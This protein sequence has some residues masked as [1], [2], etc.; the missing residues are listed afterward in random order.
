M[1]TKDPENVYE[2]RAM[3]RDAKQS[4]PAVV[5]DPILHSKV[6]QTPKHIQ[7]MKDGK[8]PLE[9][10]ITSVEE[11]DAR[12]LRGGAIKYG[13]RNWLIDKILASTYDGAI[14]RH[15][16]LWL[17]GNDVDPDSG[18]HPFYHI[19]ACCAIVLDAEKNGMLVDDRDR[20]ESISQ[21]QEAEQEQPDE[22]T[23]TYI[24]RVT[25]APVTSGPGGMMTQPRTKCFGPFDAFGE[26]KNFARDNRTNHKD[27]L[28][29]DAVLSV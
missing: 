8:A 16:K 10:L 29:I 28:S 13:V 11:G 5:L 7:A 12:V 27:T 23:F 25:Y 4:V 14:R 17:E 21:D 6:K 20:A 9:Y 15:F 26:A 19:R 3:I 22:P 24:V 1:A 2:A 18:E